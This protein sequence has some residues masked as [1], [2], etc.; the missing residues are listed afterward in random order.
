M[1]CSR[2]GDATYVAAQ[3]EHRVDWARIG[4]SGAGAMAAYSADHD[5]PMT[6]RRSYRKHRKSR[7]R[8]SAGS[9]RTLETRRRSSI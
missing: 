4:I 5:L 3:Q 1:S 6:Q 7:S 2:K 9:A 8:L